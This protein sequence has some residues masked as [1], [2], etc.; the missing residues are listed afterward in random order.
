[1]IAGFCTSVNSRRL[2]PVILASLTLVGQIARAQIYYS[3]SFETEDGYRPGPVAGISSPWKVDRKPVLV[4]NEDYYGGRQSLRIPAA[5]P[6]GQVHLTSKMLA[7]ASELF[8]DFYVR[9]FATEKDIEFLDFD[10]AMLAFVRHENG[11]EFLVY[12]ALDAT[13]GT[14]ISTG[15][16]FGLDSDGRTKNWLRVTVQRNFA[17]GTWNLYVNSELLFYSVRALPPDSNT[18][19]SVYFAGYEDGDLWMDDFY[20]G[21]PNPFLVTSEVVESP[22]NTEA[23]EARQYPQ[24]VGSFTQAR[25]QSRIEQQKQATETSKLHVEPKLQKW[26]VEGK[27][28]G[29]ESIPKKWISLD[30]TAPELIAFAPRFDEKGKPLPMEVTL[31]ADIELRPGVD[32]RRLHWTI[33]RL[34]S[35][36]EGPSGK[37]LHSGTFSGTLSC[38][39]ALTGQ[40][41]V[42]GFETLV[43]VE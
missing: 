19:R 22:A 2:F 16:R 38:T 1:M 25:A 7:H 36:W 28:G 41:V 5:T 29:E 37:V 18:A 4:S 14:W 40:E 34:R 32:L 21:E 42:Q 10:G 6:F 17:A 15:R 8:V 11:G 24:T 20:I 30:G 9:P 43:F 35:K 26:A 3:T 39:V 27:Q 23:P 12:H 33:S 13:R 31:T